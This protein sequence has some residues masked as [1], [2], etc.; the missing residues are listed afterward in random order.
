MPAPDCQLGPHCGDGVVDPEH[1]ACDR[2]DLNGTG[3]TTDDLGPCN[4]SCGF[5]GRVLFITSEEFTG[6]LGG[7]SGGDLKCRT[8][9]L[10]ADLPNATEYRAWLSDE[11]MAPINRFAQWGTPTIPII[12]VGGLIVADDFDELTDFGPRTGIARTQSGDVLFNARVW[13]NTSAFGEV[14]SATNHC[15]GWTS[16]SDLLLA[17]TGLNA[18]PVEDGP[19]WETWRDD[20]LWTNYAGRL[21][22]LPAHLY[23]IDDSVILPE[24][25]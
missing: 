15:A 6:A 21:C 23:C 19:D 11:T 9:A 8:A 3:V 25:D 24:E 22:N 7:V 12:L 4:K 5:F 2:G 1:E 14:F 10:A 20:R 18:L 17:R 16:A 13:T